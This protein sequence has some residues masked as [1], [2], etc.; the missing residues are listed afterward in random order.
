MQLLSMIILASVG[1]AYIAT[2]QIGNGLLEL[3]LATVIAV[4]DF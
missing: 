1:I 4:I 2:G 3:V